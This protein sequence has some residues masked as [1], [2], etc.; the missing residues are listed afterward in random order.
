M[1]QEKIIEEKAET[2]LRSFHH[3]LSDI[4]EDEVWR[5]QAAV[6]VADVFPGED[7]GPIIKAMER[8]DSP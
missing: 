6:F 5:A 1:S 2:I 8:I 3:I 4:D 7:P